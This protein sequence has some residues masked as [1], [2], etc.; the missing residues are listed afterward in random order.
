MLAGNSALG[1]ADDVVLDL[2]AGWYVVPELDP[3]PDS[4]SR[5]DSGHLSFGRGPQLIIASETVGMPYERQLPIGQFDIRQ[6]CV[7]LKVEFLQ[8]LNS[9][10]I[11]CIP[12]T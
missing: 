5:I 11:H 6:C 2:G 8:M 3:L 10:F 4:P 7:R 1:T 9:K 12:K